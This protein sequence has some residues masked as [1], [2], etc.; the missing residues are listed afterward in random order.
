MVLLEGSGALENNNYY[1][2]GSSFIP[3]IN[4]Q[5]GFITDNPPAGRGM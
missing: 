2:V 1:F 5:L 4:T 3:P